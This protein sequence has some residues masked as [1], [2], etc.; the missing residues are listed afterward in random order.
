MKKQFRDFNDA[1]KFVQRLGLKGVND[2][3][4]YCKSGKKPN[5]VPSTPRKVYKNMWKGWGDWLGT[6]KVAN[7]NKKFRSFDDARK[8]VHSLKLSNSKEWK[9]YCTYEKPNDIP[10]H[11]E[12]AYQHEWKGWTDWLGVVHQHGRYKQMWNFTEAR[13]FIH[14]QNL[15]SETQWRN[16]K[17][18]GKLPFFIPSSPEKKYRKEWKGWT[19]WLGTNVV[20]SKYG[21]FIDYQDA[22]KFVRTLKINGYYGWWKYCKS[23]KRPKNIPTHPDKIYRDEWNGWT[24]WT[25]KSKNLK[26]NQK[27][28]KSV[29]SNSTRSFNEARKFIQSLNLKNVNEWVEY[30]KSGNKP[31]DIPSTPRKVYK[32]MWKGYGDWL[33]TGTI[34]NQDRNKKYLSFEEAKKEAKRLAIMYN[35]KSYE[36]WKKAVK[37]GKIPSNIPTQPW[38]TYSKM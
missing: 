19:D 13:K 16:F 24:D 4:E 27:T 25:G 37:D 8:F 3:T 34:S 17:A 11:P 32:N 7:Q 9:K 26:S 29:V 15:Q 22:K 35:I 5:D 31:K 10:T 18:E 23:G 1:K 2:W 6:F 28:V 30:C 14:K 33:G 38:Q 36:D 12:L 20:G 21:K